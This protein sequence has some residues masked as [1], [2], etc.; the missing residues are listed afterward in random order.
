MVQARNGWLSLNA[1][2][3]ISKIN[4]SYIRIDAAEPHIHFEL[5]EHFSFL[6]PG[7]QF[8]PKYRNKMWDGKIR[9]YN[10]ALHKIYF[11]LLHHVREFCEERGYS[12]EYDFDYEIKLESED[13]DFIKTE[14]FYS[15]GKKIDP[16][17]Y[18][19]E[20]YQECLNKN[21]CT[22]ISPTASGK[23]L[24][25]Y[26]LV[27]RL[28][29]LTEGRILIVVPTTSLSVQMVAD[30]EDYSNNNSTWD[31]AGN[32]QKIFHGQKIDPNKRVVVSTWQSLYKK[33]VS[34]FDDI[35]V[36][37]GDECHA[38]KA[39]QISSVVDKCT[40]A[41]FRFGFTGTLDN[42]ACNKQVIQGLFG[43]V[44][45]FTSTNSLIEEN[46]LSKFRIYCLSLKYSKAECKEVAGSTYQ[47]E[48]KFIIGNQKRLNYINKLVQTLDGNS[49]VLF[50]RVESHG[51]PLF[52]L[53]KE[54]N[55]N[56][57]VFLVY[58]ATKVEV[59][60]QVRNYVETHDN[61]I[62]VAS[63]QIFSTGINITTLK[64]IILA[65]PSKSKIRNLQSIGR[66]LRKSSIK[67][68][69]YLFDIVDDLRYN[70]KSNYAIK[71]FM[72]RLQL[73]MEEKFKF[74]IK[75][76]DIDKIN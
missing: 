3:I 9:L 66:V 72:E 27:R 52:N 15:N 6:V 70:K 34:Y 14:P 12:I 50:T 71:H 13:L 68:V 69:A 51:I 29:D 31:A 75:E 74:K 24:I 28:F 17:Y 16:R 18:Q 10:K 8:T 47:D 35:D 5:F 55:K 19:I 60:E 58:G 53:I 67:N 4:E 76:V 41:I 21:R 44:A 22:I 33:P 64:N 54:S 38:F 61:C 11:G 57:D 73:Y 7:Y 37:I 43:K 32:C 23:S 1:D 62:I 39:K 42:D 30:F 48:I 63:S 45:Q 2:V 56:K 36:V 40:N 65:S 49:L 20:A 26:A 46:S 25:I 59:R